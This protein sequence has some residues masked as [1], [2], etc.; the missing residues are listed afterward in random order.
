MHHMPI[1]TV[2]CRWVNS[3]QMGVICGF[4]FSNSWSMVEGLGFRGFDFGI[5]AQMK[6]GHQGILLR[7]KGCFLK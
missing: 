7:G 6:M 1:T 3:A 4:C 2:I 5:L